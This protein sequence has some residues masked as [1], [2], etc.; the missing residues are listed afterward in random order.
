[1]RIQGTQNPQEVVLNQEVIAV[2]A[3][4]IAGKAARE[5]AEKARKGDFDASSAFDPI[6]E[7]RRPKL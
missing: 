2:V 5:A 1:M 6:R 3:N 4:Q 7:R